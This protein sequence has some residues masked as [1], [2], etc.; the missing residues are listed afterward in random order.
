MTP[1]D[2]TDS[3][4]LKSKVEMSLAPPFIEFM[5]SR[6]L[7]LDQ[8]RPGSVNLREPDIVCLDSQGNAVGIE[9]AAAHYDGEASNLWAHLRGTP[10]RS[11]R[12]MRPGEDLRTTLRRG[13]VLVNFT[14]Q[15][16]GNLQRTMNEHCAKTYAVPTYLLLDGRAGFLD[17]SDRAD[18]IL[19]GLTV[20]A[21]QGFLGIY[22]AL[23]I[24][25]SSAVAVFQVRS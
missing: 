21:A 11:T 7:A 4:A 8:P 14:D 15:L 2:P 9:V 13:P 24:N 25:G 10:E 19:E 22:L 3:A 1:T 18:E 6:G 20:P 12:W 16:I 23:P 5:A 17:T